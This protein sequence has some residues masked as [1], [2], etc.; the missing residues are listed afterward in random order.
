MKAQKPLIQQLT[1][2]VVYKNPW[3]TVKEDTVRWPSGKEGIYGYVEIPK[4]V[5]IVALDDEQ[6]V[7]LCQQYRYIFQQFNWE[8]PRG[9]VNQGET[10]LEAAKR[11]LQ[12]E[13]GVTVQDMEPLGFMWQSVGLINEE[14]HL[15]LAH[16]IKAFQP[17]QV[18]SDEI[19]K[20][21]KFPLEEVVEKIK[22]NEITDGLT[23]G[24]VL[25]AYEFLKSR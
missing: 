8:I 11:E 17:K 24:A 14:A 22:A 12:E 18:D 20:V 25:K 3:I 9:F 7:F 2:K 6:N 21:A 4:T 19:K 5:G 1:S 16:H 23:V 13:A 10:T 15:F